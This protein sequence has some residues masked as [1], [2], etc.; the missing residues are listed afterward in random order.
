MSDRVGIWLALL[1]AGLIGVDLLVTGG[2]GV[3]F[4]ARRLD[5][6]IAA[7]AFWR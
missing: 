1:A 6:Q 4:L 7:I 2:A 5:S 3:M